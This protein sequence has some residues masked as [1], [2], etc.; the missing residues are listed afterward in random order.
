MANG[1]PGDAGGALGV[2]DVRRQA[3]LVDLLERERHGDQAAVE[4]GHGDL[5]RGVE[6]RDALVVVLPGRAAA[7]QAQRLQDRDVEGRSSAPASQAS[8]SPPAER[9]GRLGA[10]R[11]EDGGHD[12]V[13]R[14]ASA[15]ISSGSSA[16]RRE[17]TTRSAARRPPLGLDRVAQ[18]LD[19]R[20][21]PAHVVGAVVEHRDRRTVVGRACAARSS[22]S[23]AR[24]RRGCVEPVTG[25]QHGVGEEAG[26]LVEVRGA[27]VREVDVGL[28][29]RCRPARWT[30]PSAGRRGPV[31]R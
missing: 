22:A 20:G 31:H 19:E 10:A 12:G 27:A 13:G 4:L 16:S 24:R 7:G 18:R 30:A 25:E 29:R 26:E 2:G 21:V 14:R 6:R 11:G 23:P 9:G 8:S 15:S 5:G 3:V 28:R 17:A 1:D